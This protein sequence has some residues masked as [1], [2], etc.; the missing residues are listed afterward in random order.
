MRDFDDRFFFVIVVVVAIVVI[1]VSIFFSSSFQSMRQTL[2]SNMIKSKIK[3]IKARLHREFG[4][5]GSARRSYKDAL[6][7]PGAGS[8]VP[9]L[10]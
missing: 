9:G 8:T 7:W 10:I 4:E 3:K 2:S 6:S 1:V 5:W